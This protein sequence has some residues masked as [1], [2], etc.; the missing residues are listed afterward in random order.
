MLNALS[1]AHDR[2]RRDD[3]AFRRLELKH[4][5]YEECRESLGAKRSLS[6][7]VKIE[8]VRLKKMKLAARDEMEQVLRQ[9]RN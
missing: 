1:D 5:E 4:L 3:H 2:L 9:A 7:A 6:E 8:V